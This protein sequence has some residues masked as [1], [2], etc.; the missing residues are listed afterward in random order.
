MSL[1]GQ[2]IELV[3]GLKTGALGLGLFTVNYK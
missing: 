2:P 1:T 3:E